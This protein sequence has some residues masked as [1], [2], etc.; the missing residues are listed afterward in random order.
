MTTR[1][2]VRRPSSP[3]TNSITLDRWAKA[4]KTNPD[5]RPWERV[6]APDEPHNVPPGAAL[7][8]R[9]IAQAGAR[10]MVAARAGLS[11]EQVQAVE[12]DTL[13]LVNHRQRCSDALNTFPAAPPPV[14]PETITALA[15]AVKL[16]KRWPSRKA[17]P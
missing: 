2:P 11:L 15:A 1:T 5:H 16:S 8:R 12:A 9:S 6:S 7:E 14:R 3:L 13:G 17:Q 10:G 4:L